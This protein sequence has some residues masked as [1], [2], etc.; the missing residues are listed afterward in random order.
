M[1]AEADENRK[2]GMN[3][4][5]KESDALDKQIAMLKRELEGEQSEKVRQEMILIKQQSEV[6][7]LK[8]EVEISRMEIEELSASYDMQMD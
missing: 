4:E 5:L 6:E 3:D 8:E 2:F 1:I 7:E